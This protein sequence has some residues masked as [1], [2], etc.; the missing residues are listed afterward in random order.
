MAK[1]RVWLPFSAGV[2]Y[3]VEVDDPRNIE[4]VKEELLEKDPSDWDY[5]P[6]FYECLGSNFDYFVSKLT[7]DDV[8]P[9][10]ED[11]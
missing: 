11:G 2:P 5:D 8:E 9:E 10:I 3:T 1:V 7:V 4:A 6:D